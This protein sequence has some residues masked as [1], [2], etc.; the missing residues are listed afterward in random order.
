[1]KQILALLAIIS[2]MHPATAAD[3]NKSVT[4]AAAG[5][6]ACDA[7]MKGGDADD[8][9][10]EGCHQ[11][12]TA[13]LIAKVH[14][15]LVL[16]LGDEQ[17]DV[18][19]LAA[20]KTMYARAWGRFLAITRPAP[21]NHEYDTPHAAGYYAYYGS[22]AGDPSK[23]YYSFDRGKWHFIAINA[24]C[25]DIGGCNAGSPEDLWLKADLAKQKGRCILAYWHQ[26]R[27]SS[28]HHHSDPTYT[29]FWKDLYAAKADVVLNG[30][31]PLYERFGPQTPNGK[32]DP[33]HGVRE[34]I[35]GTGGRS[36]YVFKKTEPNSEVRNNTAF[37]IL[38][39]RLHP[40]SY[41]WNFMPEAGKTFTDRGSAHCHNKA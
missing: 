27:F 4:V 2:L 19:A 23:G 11:Q 15:D 7:S 20:F 24:N 3:S 37:G 8:A 34:F 28:G 22:K 5:D 30:H 13:D 10:R 9:S 21:G 1:M 25:T 18:G 29:D 39:L 36:H 6:I 12:T 32:A 41:D 17:Y 33:A 35:A 40:Y 38:V 16:P 31:D 26:P 14:P